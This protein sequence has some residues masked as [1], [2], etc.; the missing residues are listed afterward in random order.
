[1]KK[2]DNND[3][4]AVVTFVGIFSVIGFMILENFE[5]TDVFYDVPRIEQPACV[6]DQII[7]GRDE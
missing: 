3:W 4:A 1:M 6:G 2:W 5:V 7:V